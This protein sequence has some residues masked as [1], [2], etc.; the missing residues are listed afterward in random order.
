MIYNPE[1][2]LSIQR[3]IMSDL[4]LPILLG[5]ALLSPFIM[6]GA[7]YLGKASKVVPVISDYVE[8]Y[9]RARPERAE[10]NDRKG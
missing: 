4:V 6:I 5:Y 7:Y 9:E 10:K 3:M 1:L 8:S 2:I